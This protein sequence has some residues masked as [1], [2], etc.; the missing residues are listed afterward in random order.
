MAERVLSGPL[1]L[2]KYLSIEAKGLLG[3]LLHRDPMKRLGTRHGSM[4]IR[5]HP[6]FV[7][8]DWDLATFREV[9]PPIQPCQSSCAVVSCMKIRL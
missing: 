7:S 5:T 1:Q 6:F 4:E 3:T 2:P 9:H 8:I